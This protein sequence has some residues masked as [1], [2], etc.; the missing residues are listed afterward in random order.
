MPKKIKITKD[1]IEKTMKIFA[2]NDFSFILYQK[3][4]GSVVWANS[5][6]ERLALID[7]AETEKEYLKLVRETK[8]MKYLNTNHSKDQKDQ[9]NVNYMG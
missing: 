2:E 1:Y 6:G 7:I 5:P 4:F 8:A 9:T 3:D